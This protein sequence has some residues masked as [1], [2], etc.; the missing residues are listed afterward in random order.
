[1]AFNSEDVLSQHVIC[2]GK[3]RFLDEL[4]GFPVYSGF[5]RF[6]GRQQWLGVVSRQS[7]QRSLPP[8]GID[9]VLNAIRT[10]LQ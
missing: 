7:L 8:N 1:M 6:V 4:D 10:T 9:V 5:F 2:Y 3:R